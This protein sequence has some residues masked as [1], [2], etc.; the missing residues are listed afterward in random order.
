MNSKK[1]KADEKLQKNHNL[2]KMENTRVFWGWKG[3]L[4]FQKQCLY[5]G[6]QAK[7]NERWQGEGGMCLNGF[8][9]DISNQCQ[10][11]QYKSCLKSFL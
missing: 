6:H 9:A 7:D 2:E 4:G 5:K 8:Y 1:S 3:D 11:Q 10:M